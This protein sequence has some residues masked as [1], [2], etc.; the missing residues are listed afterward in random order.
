M[1]KKMGRWVRRWEGERGTA[2][3]SS[4]VGVVVN[5]Y[6]GHR[7]GTPGLGRGDTFWAPR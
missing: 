7:F 1:G 5:K 3:V 6:S 2:Q 4:S